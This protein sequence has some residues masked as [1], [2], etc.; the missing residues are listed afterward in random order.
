M[1]HGGALRSRKNISGFGSPVDSTGVRTPDRDTNGAL[2]PE[3]RTGRQDDGWRGKPAA[4]KGAQARMP[5]PLGEIPRSARPSGAQTARFAPASER[6]G[7]APPL[8]RKSS[9]KRGAVRDEARPRGRVL[10]AAGG[11]GRVKMW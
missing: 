5:V 1:G 4:I 8:R 3:K 9:G 11:Y 2:P 10:R 6:A 7:Q